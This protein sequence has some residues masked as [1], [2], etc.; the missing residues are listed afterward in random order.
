MDP[1]AIQLGSISYSCGPV[2]IILN[3]LKGLC[4]ILVFL[5]VRQLGADSAPHQVA[6]FQL[7]MW[8]LKNDTT[9]DR[10][11]SPLEVQVFCCSSSGATLYCF[12]LR[13]FRG[14]L[15]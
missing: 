7:W 9:N 2:L 10:S 6:G 11:T 13:C 5:P 3:R 14:Y 4:C 15:L 12:F 8:G 1:V